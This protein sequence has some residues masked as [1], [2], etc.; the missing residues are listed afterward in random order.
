M[1]QSLTFIYRNDVWVAEGWHDLDLSTNVNHVL[2]I[3]D[4]LLPDRLD[5]HLDTED[6]ARGWSGNKY[7]KKTFFSILSNLWPFISSWLLQTNVAQHVMSGR[8]PNMW[9][10]SVCVAKSPFLINCVFFVDLCSQEA[11]ATGFDLLV[12]SCRDDSQMSQTWRRCHLGLSLCNLLYMVQN[13]GA[14]FKKNNL[15]RGALMEACFVLCQ[16]PGLHLTRVL[17]SVWAESLIWA[18]KQ[19]L[20]DRSVVRFT[21]WNLCSP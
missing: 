12:R 14:L 6:K 4:L 1:K 15:T 10:K 3:L 9:A 13:E 8:E 18:S 11:C 21:W 16:G 7:Q 2:L 17:V 19:S 5:R 20:K